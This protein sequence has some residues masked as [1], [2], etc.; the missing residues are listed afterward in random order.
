[1][2]GM[3]SCTYFSLQAKTVTWKRS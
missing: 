2:L 1:M 3:L